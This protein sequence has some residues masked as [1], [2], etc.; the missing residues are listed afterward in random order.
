MFIECQNTIHFRKQIGQYV[1]AIYMPHT[2]NNIVKEEDKEHAVPDK[3][4]PVTLSLTVTVMLVTDTI[5]LSHNAY[6]IMHFSY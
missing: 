6:Q 4:I 3:K 1:I 5:R 2:R